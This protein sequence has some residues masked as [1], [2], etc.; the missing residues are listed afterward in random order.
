MEN[1]STDSI[2]DA[3]AASK[4]VPSPVTVRVPSEAQLKSY[5]KIIMSQ[6]DMTEDDV[7]ASLTLNEYNPV[8]VIRSYMLSN[9]SESSSSEKTVFTQS[10][11]PSSTNQLRF[12]EIRGFMDMAADKFRRNQEMNKIYQQVMERKKQIAMARTAALEA[13]AAAEKEAQS[14]L[15]SVSEESTTT[16]DTETTTSS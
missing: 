5:V 13:A 14:K 3:P 16:D 9:R 1:T 4:P 2:V 12:N 10:A 6:T 8:K 11:V 15:T 7:L